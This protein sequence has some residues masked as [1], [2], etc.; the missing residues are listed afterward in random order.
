MIFVMAGRRK[1]RFG[2][3]KASGTLRSLRYASCRSDSLRRPIS[4]LSVRFVRLSFRSLRPSFSAAP[5]LPLGSSF[6]SVAPTSFSYDAS[7]RRF[8]QD[9]CGCGSVARSEGALRT[10]AGKRQAVSRTPVRPFLSFGCRECFLSPG[11]RFLFASLR[12]IYPVR[13]DRRMHG[14]PHPAKFAFYG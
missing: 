3:G 8:P 11:R 1:G 6:R 2:L 4:L 12:L 9:S 5:F 7:V 13:P 14:V 10:A